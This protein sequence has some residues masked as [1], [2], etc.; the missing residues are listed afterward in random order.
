MKET[1]LSISHPRLWYAWWSSSITVVFLKK[2]M[3]S[4][5]SPSAIFAAPRVGEEETAI[6]VLFVSDSCPELSVLVDRVMNA[7]GMNSGV[8][9]GAAS[10]EGNGR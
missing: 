6:A 8:S 1:K 3:S 10:I 9:H 5:I 4:E 7:M 2:S